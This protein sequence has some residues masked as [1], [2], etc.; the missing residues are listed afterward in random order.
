[1][2]G[3]AWF[4]ESIAI[5]PKQGSVVVDDCEIRW[6]AWGE[7]GAPTL[8]LVHGG[9]AHA[10]WWAPH[11][12]MLTAGR[13]V[14]AIDLSGHGD[15]GW[16]EVYRAEQWA[17]EVLAVA[18]DAGGS[19][20]PVVAGHSMGGFVTIVTA[21][22]HGRELEGAIVLDSPV[23]RPD[24]ESD[25]GRGGGRR[26]FVQR[27]VYPDRDAILERFKLIP[28]Q[29]CENAWFLDYIARN[30]IREE[31]EGGWTWK[32]DPGVFVRREGSHR[33][34]DFAAR[35][36]EVTCR[37]AVVNG[38]D[39][40]IVDEDVVSYMSDLLEGSPAAAAGVPFVQVPRAHHHLLLDQPLATVTAIRGVLA[41][42][43]PVGEPPVD[44]N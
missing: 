10:R 19:G 26:G 34:I 5:E 12:P 22:E 16:R 29:P 17:Q 4:E 43:S 8:V 38:E 1:L 40:A 18:A 13:R 35:L 27:R 32:F 15:S 9:A 21:A 36:A 3:P 11:A 30:S 20:R 28:P 2:V 24:P 44:V 37:I 6:L 7:R 31:P 33:P 25:E 42:W 41:T 14:V 39:S 23:R